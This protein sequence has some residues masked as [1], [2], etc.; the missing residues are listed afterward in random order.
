MNNRVTVIFNDD[1]LRKLN[2]ICTARNISRSDLFRKFVD[3]Q[4]K[5]LEEEP[6]MNEM[7][8]ELESMTAQINELSQKFIE[9]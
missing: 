4:Y 7:I 6:K 8:K 3:T 9:Q 1:Y 5:L 2:S